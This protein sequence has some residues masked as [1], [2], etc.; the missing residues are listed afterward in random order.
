MR[1]LKMKTRIVM[2]ICVVVAAGELTPV[3]AEMGKEK[4]V[5][6]KKAP[7]YVRCKRFTEIGSLVAQKKICR[8]NAEW[9][10]EGD[11]ENAAARRF[12]QQNSGLAPG[13]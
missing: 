8:T 2:A 5:V 11:L 7:D 1:N 10:K 3:I 6:D 4:A 9:G 13:N 12:V